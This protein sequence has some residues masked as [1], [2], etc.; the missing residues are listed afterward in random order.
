MLRCRNLF[1]LRLLHLVE[2]PTF[3]GQRDQLRIQTLSAI[4]AIKP[5]SK[6]IEKSHLNKSTSTQFH[7]LHHQSGE[8]NVHEPAACGSCG[9][10]PGLYALP[11]TIGTETFSAQNAIDCSCAF[12]VAVCVC[13]FS[14]A[15]GL[16]WSLISALGAKQ[17]L[18]HVVSHLIL[19]EL[20]L[21]RMDSLQTHWWGY[22][23]FLTW[24]DS[25]MPVSHLQLRA[26][27]WSA[28]QTPFWFST[29]T[30]KPREQL[31]HRGL[32]ARNLRDTDTT[33]KGSSSPSPSFPANDPVPAP[34]K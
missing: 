20:Q 1:A 10:Q 27:H 8:K 22:G 32:G 29:P 21:L 12:V 24:F 25:C 16:Q 7:L 9:G 23:Y 5:R 13:E 34:K 28:H 31:L 14:I 19:W 26:A 15:E 2:S 4:L 6:S 30:D 33:S 18:H 17:R 3:L 11:N